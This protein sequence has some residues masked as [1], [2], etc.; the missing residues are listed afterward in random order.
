MGARACDREADVRRMVRNQTDDAALRLHAERCMAC[1]E[2]LEVAVWMRQMAALP[3]DGASRPDPVYLWWKA[4][5]LRQWDAERLV[6]APIEAWSRV[7]V[8]IGLVA[9]AVLLVLV[10]E[11]APVL[12]TYR[13]GGDRP[14]WTGVAGAMMPVLIASAL[15]L[16][17]TAIV[18]ARDWMDAE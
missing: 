14:S 16:V 7:A 13:G 17:A 1:R 4:K 11:E 3:I 9:A 2:T 18:M 8:A 12:T 15:L 5:L 6:Q 10:W